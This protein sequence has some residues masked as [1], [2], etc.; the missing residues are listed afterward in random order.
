MG[1]QC[2]GNFIE[3]IDNDNDN[4]TNFYGS[5]FSPLIFLNQIFQ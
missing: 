1:N 4:Q 3:M 2:N 5:K